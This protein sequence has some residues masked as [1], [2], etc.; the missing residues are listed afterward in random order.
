MKQKHLEILFTILLC[1]FPFI[2]VILDIIY[3]NKA[4]CPNC[5]QIIEK[6]RKCPCC[7]RREK[8]YNPQCPYCQCEL[9]WS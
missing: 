8:E 1:V 7:G 4:S 6:K 9:T 3:W 2:F 5:K